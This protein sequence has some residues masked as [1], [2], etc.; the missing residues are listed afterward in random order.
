MPSRRLED[1]H[2][3]L[4]K[5]WGDSAA[6]WEALHPDLPKPIITCTYRSN[7]EQ[8]ELY[9]QGRTKKGKIVTRAKAG[10]SPHNHNPSFAFDIAFVKGKELDWRPMLFSFFAAIVKQVSNEVVWGGDFKSMVDKPHFELKNY[11]E[12]I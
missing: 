5:V 11:R 4:V 2:P 7:E 10:Q 9:A 1:L 12:M 6:R 3:T 8:T